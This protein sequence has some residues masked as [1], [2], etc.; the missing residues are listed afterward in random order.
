MFFK[1]TVL[2]NSEIY[3]GK[4]LCWSLFLIK[5]QAL[6]ANA[7]VKFAKILRIPFFYRTPVPL[8]LLR[9]LNEETFQII[10]DI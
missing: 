10:R 1:L 2:K 5:L 7:R 3:S 4:H 9:L 8:F 6:D